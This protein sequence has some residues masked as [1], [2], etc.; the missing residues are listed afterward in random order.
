MAAHSTPTDYKAFIESTNALHHALVTLQKY[1]LIFLYNVPSQPDAITHI[2]NRV[3]LIRNTIYGSTWDVRPVPSAKNVAYTACH[4]GFHMDLL[5]MAD[6]PELQILHCLGASKQG[7]ESLFSDTLHAVELMR[8]QCNPLLKSLMEFPV[9]YWY[10]NDGFNFQHTK[11]T[12][13]MISPLEDYTRQ[14]DNVSQFA[15]TVKAVNWSPPFQAPLL[16]DIGDIEFHSRAGNSLSNYLESIKTFKKLIEDPAS[17]FET[18][19]DE[20]TCVIFNNRR[21][22]HARRAFS[23]KEGKRWLRG[24]YVDGDAFRSR[25]RILEEERSSRVGLRQ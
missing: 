15:T 20:G 17:V 2:S 8:Q 24:A 1:G 5:Y 18:K 6:P 4:L 10:K 3:G 25:M 19:L 23:D 14:A 12:I 16:F 7:G 9:T 13:E 21:I 22:V 11:R